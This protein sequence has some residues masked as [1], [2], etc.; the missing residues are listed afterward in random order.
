[1]LDPIFLPLED[2]RAR[3]RLLREDDS[4]AYAEGTN[5]PMVRKYAH[6]PEP[7]YTPESVAAMIEGPVREGF[8]RGDLAVLA[9]AHP[10][11]DQFAGSLVLFDASGGRAEVGFWLHPAARGARMADSALSLAERFAKQSGLDSLAARAVTENQ[12]SHRILERAGF[13][14]V[15]RGADTV[16]SGQTVE[17]VQYV[18]TL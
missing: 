8:K 10:E 3:L 9:I 2:A 15:G 18:R 1:M 5:D 16:P 6:L 14:E 13:R 11:S 4:T 7:H 17:T 12:R